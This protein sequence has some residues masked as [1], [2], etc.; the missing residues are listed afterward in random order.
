MCELLPSTH[1]IH[2]RTTNWRPPGE[3]S[4]RNTHTLTRP[5]G[6]VNYDLIWY[7]RA[8]ISD[9]N[10]QACSGDFSGK[11][12]GFLNS[13]PHDRHVTLCLSYLIQDDK[14]SM[15]LM[16]NILT[17]PQTD[18]LKTSQ[19]DFVELIHENLTGACLLKNILNTSKQ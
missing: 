15:I 5:A 13:I 12:H 2:S 17:P 3:Q 8:I 16:A 1:S 11:H 18:L 6:H 4:G 10:S 14:F 19:N 7:I 9:K